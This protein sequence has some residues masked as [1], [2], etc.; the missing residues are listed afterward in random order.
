M[1]MARQRHV[2]YVLKSRRLRQTVDV[3]Y[4]LQ[5]GSSNVQP[6]DAAAAENADVAPC[7]FAALD[8]HAA[9]VR[10]RGVYTTRS[11]PDLTNQPRVPIPV[12]D[13]VGLDTHDLKA[14]VVGSNQIDVLKPHHRPEL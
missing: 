4:V 12:L 3:E 11:T 2:P 9:G 6:L 1:R 5:A 13:A 14:L 7:N 10:Q 8:L